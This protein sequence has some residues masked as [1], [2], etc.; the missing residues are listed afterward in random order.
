LLTKFANV[1]SDNDVSAR[2]AETKFGFNRSKASAIFS[3][4]I[5]HVV[6]M[7]SEKQMVRANTS[8]IITMMTNL[9]RIL[10]WSI[11]HFIGNSVSVFSNTL[12]PVHAYKDG[13]VRATTATTFFTNPI[14]TILRF[15]DF[16]PKLSFKF[17]RK[18]HHG[19]ILSY[20]RMTVKL[21]V[22]VR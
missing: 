8:R 22:G 20:Q 4:H 14:P 9:Q 3:K 19:H 5:S 10:K 15:V 13:A 17:F 2:S 1:F 16:G 6:S 21:L 11:S 18:F 12:L 7:G